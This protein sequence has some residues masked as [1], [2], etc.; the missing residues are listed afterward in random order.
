MIFDTHAHY[1]DEQFDKDRDELLWGMEDEG[2]G[3]IV[4]IGASM[5]SSREAIR[6][7]EQYPFVYASVGVHPDH[8]GELNEETFGELDRMCS[9]GKV[10]AVGE[11]GLDYHW[12]TEPREIQKHWFI[13]QLEL[14]AAKNLPVNIHGGVVTFKNG[15]KLKEIATEIPLERIVL[16]TDCPY[17]APEPNRGRRNDSRNIHYVAEQIA[18]LKGISKETVIKQTENNAKLI[19]FS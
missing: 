17:L 13:R 4:E 15:R 2:V 12:D 3:T 10:R 16:E 1:S 18:Q 7:A 9:H 6:L 14:A 8:V 11:I 5:E 19:Y